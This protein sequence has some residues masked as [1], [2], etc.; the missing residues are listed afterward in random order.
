MHK[1]MIKSEAHGNACDYVK[2]CTDLFEAI[3][4]KKFS[5][6]K[7]G[8][9]SDDDIIDNLDEMGNNIYHAASRSGRSDAIQ[10]LN[11][12]KSNINSL[13]NIGYA[14][15]HLACEKGYLDCVIALKMRG[16][17]LNI[18]TYPDEMTPM[19]LA[20]RGGHWP[21]INFLL[22]SGCS[23][24]VMNA[25]CKT[26][27]D[28]AVEYG[29]QKAAIILAESFDQVVPNVNQ[30][31]PE[32]RRP[33]AEFLKNQELRRK[34]QLYREVQESKQNNKTFLD[35]ARD[36]YVRE[37]TEVTDVGDVVPEP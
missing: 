34:R 28:F 20:A 31:S 21:I 17:K 32:L 25:N 27:I 7:E 1:F 9:V 15:I 36:A 12:R 2:I 6:L 14:P 10:W 22:K 24:I 5:L 13:N 26:P 29:H 18:M 3:K 37:M 4:N 33:S 8:F 35:A 30:I 11:L 23:P 16:A 19:H